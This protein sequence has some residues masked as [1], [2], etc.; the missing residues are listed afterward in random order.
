MRHSD[1]HRYQPQVTLK[2][3]A[4]HG[5]RSH[6]LSCQQIFH[7]DCQPLTKTMYIHYFIRL[8]ASGKPRLNI[9]Y[10]HNQTQTSK[11]IMNWCSA[12]VSATSSATVSMISATSG[13]IICRIFILKTKESKKTYIK[14]NIYVYAKQ[15]IIQLSKHETQTKQTK[16]SIIETLELKKKNKR[17]NITIMMIKLNNFTN[18]FLLLPFTLYFTERVCVQKKTTSINTISYQL[19][20]YST[21]KID[22]EST[23]IR[24]DYKLQERPQKQTI[25]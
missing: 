7:V 23:A 17:V 11:V 20:P 6:S 21:P 12:P 5:S 2:N 24:H 1:C 14:L 9:K 25:A 22:E 10:D 18:L 16:S 3:M 4:Q 8:Y 15:S 19:H 13:L